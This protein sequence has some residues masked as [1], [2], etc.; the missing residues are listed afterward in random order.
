VKGRGGDRHARGYGVV[1]SK[2][3]GQQ[4]VVLSQVL[5]VELTLGQEDMSNMQ[6]KVGGGG[7]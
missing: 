2:R 6:V 4:V 7:L 3:C 1:G 5:A